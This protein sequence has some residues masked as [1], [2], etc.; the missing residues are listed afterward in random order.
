MDHMDFAMTY[1]LD[2]AHGLVINTVRRL[3]EALG[4]G[5]EGPERIAV[6]GNPIQLSVFQGIPI[7]DLAYAGEKKKEKYHI[8]DRKRES[9]IIP[10]SG[11]AGLEIYPDCQ[12]VIPPAIKHEI[13]ADALALIVNAGLPDTDEI[14]IATDFGTNAEMALKA[15]GVIYTGSAAAGPALEGQEISCGALAG[16]HT[17]SDVVLEGPYIRCYILNSEM[18]PETGDLVDPVTGISV[19]K[20]NLRAR[21]ITGTGVISLIEQGIAGGLI[22]LPKINTP[23]HVIHLQD[24]I[25]FIEKDVKEAGNL[26]AVGTIDDLRKKISEKEGFCRLL[27]VSGITPEKTAALLRE[28]PGFISSEVRDGSVILLMKND[29]RQAI[30]AMIMNAGGMILGSEEKRMSLQDIFMKLTEND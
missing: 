25:T 9:K 23:D 7:D 8:T 11:I 17:I 18:K 12:V 3:L 4:I 1:G 14:M 19:E 6:C 24:G 13:G 28:I 20:G 27:N 10:A 22:T 5:P 30:S 2:K 29:D 16:P 15:G 21:G 26:A